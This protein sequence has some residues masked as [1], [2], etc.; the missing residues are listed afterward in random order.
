M[1]PRWIGLLGSWAALVLGLGLAC[2]AAAGEWINVRDSRRLERIAVIDELLQERKA[3][4]LTRLKG[5]RDESESSLDQARSNVANALRT[6]DEGQDTAQ[7]IVVST[8]ENRVYVRKLGKTIFKAVCSTG[9][10]TTLVERGRTRGF[11]TP[12]GKFRVRSKEENPVWIPPDWHY[13]EMARKLGL[14][15]VRLREGQSI[16]ADS[17][18]AASPSGG[19]VWD[20]LGEGGPRRVFTVKNGTVVELSNG[21]VR[22]LAPGTMIRAGN[23]LVIPP[24]G[25]PQRSYIGELGAYRLNIGDGYALHGTQATSQL[26]R[27]V[28]HGCVRLG[29]DDIATLYEMTNVG[30]EVIIY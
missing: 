8:A 13:V 19:G 1:M 3:S 25:S 23:G 5:I 10:H 17:G 16:D 30:D 26:G 11:R 4:Q 28:S 27:S 22:E 6:M 29:D 24:F 12:V 14:R 21:G 20:W 7:T 9:K 18:A 2:V 15:V